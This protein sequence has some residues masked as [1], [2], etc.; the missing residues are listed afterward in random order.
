M[1]RPTLPRKVRKN[2]SWLPAMGWEV[3]MSRPMLT[4]GS[5][6]KLLIHTAELKLMPWGRDR[7]K[8]TVIRRKRPLSLR[9]KEL[10]LTAVLEVT[11]MPS[12]EWKRVRIE[13]DLKSLMKMATE[14]STS[15][16]TGAK[17]IL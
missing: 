6:G 15:R 3:K 8:L 13:K 14:V 5:T 11:S 12:L 16:A 17:P 2:L 4:E 7:I 1:L 9:W 10:S